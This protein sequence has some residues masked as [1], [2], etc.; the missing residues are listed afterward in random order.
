MR[1]A[2]LREVSA[3]ALCHRIR[4]TLIELLVVIAIIAILAAILLPALQSARKTAQSISCLNSIKQVG[5]AEFSYVD[6]YA[7]YLTFAKVRYDGVYYQWQNFLFP[8][9]YN[10]D[11]SN[12]SLSAV[13]NK[14]VVWGCPMWNKYDAIEFQDVSWR[15]GYSINVHP[16]KPDDGFGSWGSTGA[17]M[18]PGTDDFSKLLLSRYTEGSRRAYFGEGPD[19]HMTGSSTWNEACFGFESWSKGDAIRHGKKANYWFLDGHA[20]PVGYR[21]AYLAFSN[22]ALFA[23]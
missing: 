21:T 13:K 1:A 9:L 7:G 6:D 14:G 17:G 3:T 10:K 20:S 15:T 8:Y 19:W 4:F 11:Q 2:V 22:P 18:I 5:L 12:N 23:Y 16:L